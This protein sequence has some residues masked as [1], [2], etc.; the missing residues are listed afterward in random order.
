VARP[1]RI[2]YGGAFYRVTSL[3]NERRKIF[4]GK[5]DYEKLKSYLEEAKE[6]YGYLFRDIVR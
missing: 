2:E 1:P 4:S 6:K 3:G 5:A